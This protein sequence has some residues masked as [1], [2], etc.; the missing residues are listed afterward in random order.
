MVWS[1]S[2]VWGWHVSCHR[3]K[4]KLDKQVRDYPVP[5]PFLIIFGL[6]A[7]NSGVLHLALTQAARGCARG[8]DQG[9]SPSAVTSC[10]SSPGGLANIPK[11]P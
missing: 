8:Q 11:L 6:V 9:N 7:L 1:V 3:H 10:W 4:G 5:A 2:Y